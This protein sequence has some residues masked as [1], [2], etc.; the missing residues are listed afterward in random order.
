MAAWWFYSKTKKIGINYS[1]HPLRLLYLKVADALVN[2]HKHCGIIT[3][4]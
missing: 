1:K 4:L 3:T 2:I